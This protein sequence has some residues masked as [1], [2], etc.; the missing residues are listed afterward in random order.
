[1]G[2]YVMGIRESIFPVKLLIKNIYNLHKGF[3]FNRIFLAS[4]EISYY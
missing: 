1:M 4:N 2:I 3:L